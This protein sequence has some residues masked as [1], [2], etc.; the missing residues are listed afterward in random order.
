METSWKQWTIYGKV[1]VESSLEFHG[2]KAATTQQVKNLNT[3]ETSWNMHGHF[4]EHSGHFLGKF[5]WK[6]HGNFLE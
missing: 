4:M 2:K 3:M 6:V 1:P 5:L